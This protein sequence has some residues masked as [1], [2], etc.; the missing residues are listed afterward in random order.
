LTEAQTAVLADWVRLGP[1]P[2]EDKIVR[3]RLKDL[4]QRLATRFQVAMHECSVGKA[5]AQLNFSHISVRPRNPKAEKAAQEAHKK[6]SP[7]C[8]ASHSRQGT[9]TAA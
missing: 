4:Q 9:R 2:E 7:N 8:C 1:N 5:L 3:W 6:T